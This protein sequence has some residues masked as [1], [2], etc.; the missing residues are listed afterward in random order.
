M[1]AHGFNGPHPSRHG[2]KLSKLGPGIIDA[3]RLEALLA[4]D[5]GRGSAP[6]PSPGGDRPTWGKHCACA[7]PCAKWPTCRR[8][9]PVLRDPDEGEVPIGMGPEG[10]VPT[11]DEGGEA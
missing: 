4:D 9:A 3:A 11:F 8:S 7:E 5:T 10:E 6:P 2:R 1:S